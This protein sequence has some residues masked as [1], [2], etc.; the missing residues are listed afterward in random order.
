MIRFCEKLQEMLSTLIGLFLHEMLLTRTRSSFLSMNATTKGWVCFRIHIYGL[1]GYLWLHVIYFSFY[2]KFYSKLWT[3]EHSKQLWDKGLNNWFVYLQYMYIL[4]AHKM[5]PEAKM[6]VAK[7]T[8]H[9]RCD[10]IHGDVVCIF[11]D[12]YAQCACCLLSDLDVWYYLLFSRSV[13]GVCTEF[14]EAHGN[15]SEV[16]WPTTTV[17][18][19]R[20][21]L[22]QFR[23][24]IHVVGQN[25]II[26]IT[27]VELT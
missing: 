25:G 12:S 17:E 10:K 27:Q 8:K 21:Q 23:W 16:E 1:K 19:I 9:S 2:F 6:S 7:K 18:N 15:S 11:L 22:Q 5:T 13:L 24:V 26:Y 14:S 20:Q 3:N 4:F